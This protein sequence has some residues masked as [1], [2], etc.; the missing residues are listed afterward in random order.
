LTGRRALLENDLVAIALAAQE[1]VSD[2]RFTRNLDREFV[3]TNRLRTQGTD[4]LIAVAREAEVSRFESGSR[5][6]KSPPTLVHPN[7]SYACI[8]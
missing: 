5:S 2:A 6:S 8:A 7:P 1:A 3:V 4:A